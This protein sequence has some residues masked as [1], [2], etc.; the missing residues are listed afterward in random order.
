MVGLSEDYH[1]NQSQ[2]STAVV[3]FC[4]SNKVV[5]LLLRA[6][7]ASGACRVGCLQGGGPP[8]PRWDCCSAACGLDPHTV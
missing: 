6:V 8:P 3:W 2:T 4:A 7:C 5:M 1:I